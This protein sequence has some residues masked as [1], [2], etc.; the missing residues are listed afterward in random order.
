MKKTKIV[1]NSK[2]LCGV[3]IKKSYTGRLHQSIFCEYYFYSKNEKFDSNK[4]KSVVKIESGDFFM[5]DNISKTKFRLLGADSP[6][7][8]VEV[9]LALFKYFDFDYFNFFKG[10]A[11][12]FILKTKA[13]ELYHNYCELKEKAKKKPKMLDI[14]NNL[15]CLWCKEYEVSL[16]HINKR[17]AGFS[18]V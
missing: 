16:N 5:E 17:Y 11:S 6:K 18:D 3:K 15:F 13:Q 2:N 12:S 7:R 9:H 14:S 1:L 8:A 4:F 10:I